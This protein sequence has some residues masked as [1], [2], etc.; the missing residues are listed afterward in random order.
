MNAKFLCRAYL[1]SKLVKVTKHRIAFSENTP[2]RCTITVEGNPE[3]NTIVAVELG[4]GDG[5]SRV[6]L[7]Y[8]ERIQP[9]QMGYS[10][11]FCRELSALLFKP[12]NVAL[13]HPTL[14]QLL[15]DV[16]NKTGLQFVVPDKAYSK[17]AIPCFYSDGNGYRIMDEIAQAFSVD[18]FFWQ[19]QGNGQIFVGSWKD[20][21]WASKPVDIPADLM[22]GQTATKSIKVPAIPR[23]KPGV[24]VNGLRISGVE[25]EETEVKLTWKIQ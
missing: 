10:Q 7:G 18:D 22:T 21:F 4:W 17:T 1:G 13:R 5:I 24:L 12:L 20:S 25:F 14:M 11:L 16:T 15:E 23:I 2:G 8:V 6:F 3:V 9:V 19:Q